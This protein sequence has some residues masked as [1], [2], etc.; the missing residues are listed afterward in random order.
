MKKLFLSC[1]AFM[2]AATMFGQVKTVAAVA[3]FQSETIDLGSVKQGVPVTATFVVTNVSNEPLVIEQANPTCGCTIGDYTKEPIMP[4][5]SGTI[6]ATYNA[7][8]ASHFTK[9][10][11][12]KFAGIDEVKSITITGDVLDAEAYA[13]LKGGSVP[14]AVAAKPQVATSPAVAA[15]PST[16]GAKTAKAKKP[17]KGTNC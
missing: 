11:T 6:T 2:F 17:C 3:K 4:G 5:K 7:A 12:V 1:A 8:S 9:S 13:K 14:A 16:K 10:M 15:K